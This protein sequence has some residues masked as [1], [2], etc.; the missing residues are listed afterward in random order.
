MVFYACKLQG[1]FVFFQLIMFTMTMN[2]ICEWR[3]DW[4]GWRLDW[5]LPERL[6][7]RLLQGPA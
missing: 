5:Q 2:A 6:D 7:G 3:L 4:Q 1:S